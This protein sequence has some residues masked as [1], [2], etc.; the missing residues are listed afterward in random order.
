MADA[1][2]VSPT[3]PALTIRILP[4][5]LALLDRA[6]AYTLNAGNEFTV[7]EEEEQLKLLQSCCGSTAKEPDHDPEAIYGFCL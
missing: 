1:F 2:T 3:N 7:E 4:D 5:Q 6:L